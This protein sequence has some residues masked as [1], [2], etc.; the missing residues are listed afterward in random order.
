MKRRDQWTRQESVFDKTFR[1]KSVSDIE[2]DK[3]SVPHNLSIISQRKNENY[4]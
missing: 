3:E 2:E 4:T 1:N